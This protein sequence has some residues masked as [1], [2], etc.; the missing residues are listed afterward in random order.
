MQQLLRPTPESRV[1]LAFEYREEWETVA[2]FQARGT[3]S[4]L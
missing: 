3:P 4:P 1:L 2:D